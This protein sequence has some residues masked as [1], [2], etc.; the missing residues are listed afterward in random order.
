MFSSLGE[1]EPDGAQG[2]PVGGFLVS[3]TFAS[4]QGR[5]EGAGKEFCAFK[6]GFTPFVFALL[7]EFYRVK[8]NSPTCFCLCFQR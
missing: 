7:N 3:C 8:K 4:V 1:R 6:S 5:G 2:S